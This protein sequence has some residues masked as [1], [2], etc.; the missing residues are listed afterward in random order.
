M[1]H[2]IQGFWALQQCSD[3]C[4][5]VFLQILERPQNPQMF[6]FFFDQGIVGFLRVPGCSRGGGVPEEPYGVLGKIGGPNR[7]D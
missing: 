3:A 4:D 5:F 1:L 7:E 6:S 2:V